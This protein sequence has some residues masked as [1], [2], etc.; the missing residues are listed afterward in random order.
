MPEKYFTIVF[1]FHQLCWVSNG[2]AASFPP[3]ATEPLLLTELP[4]QFSLQLSGFLHISLDAGQIQPGF[5]SVK[6][7][8]HNEKN[9]MKLS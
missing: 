9:T 5:L 4:L 7:R 1:L 2:V 6:R 8:C 3:N